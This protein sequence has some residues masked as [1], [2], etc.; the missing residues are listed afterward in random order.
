MLS[1]GVVVEENVG[2]LTVLTQLGHVQSCLPFRPF[3]SGTVLGR[4]T[5]VSWDGWQGCGLW[6]VMLT[7]GSAIVALSL[8]KSQDLSPVKHW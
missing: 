2:R 7:Q 3:F 8:V 5:L 4:Q 6:A 1:L